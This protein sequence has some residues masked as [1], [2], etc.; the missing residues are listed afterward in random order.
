NDLAYI[1]DHLDTNDNLGT[2]TQTSLTGLDMIARALNDEDGRPLDQAYSVT[3]AAGAT[4]FTI[5]LS[6]TVNG[7]TTGIGTVTFAIGTS[8]ADVQA[9]L[10]LLL[11]T[12]TASANPGISLTCGTLS[13]TQCAQSVYVTKIGNDYIIGFR[14]EVNADPAHPV[15][16][17][18]FALGAGA[19]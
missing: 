18:L 10:Q 13:R 19:N 2:L 14:G 15:R 17:N 9:A 7:V 3:P 12:Q 11:Y 1:D 5:V 6:Q 8:A 16:V 4:S